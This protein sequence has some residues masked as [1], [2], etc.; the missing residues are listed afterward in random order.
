MPNWPEH[1]RGRWRTLFRRKVAGDLFVDPTSEEMRERLGLREIKQ[2]CPRY[3]TSE[4][5]RL[6]RD[7][8][9]W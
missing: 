4:V 2:D 3:R 1:Q 7:T 8:T 9:D 6:L 5:W